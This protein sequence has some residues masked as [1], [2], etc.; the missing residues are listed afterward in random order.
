MLFHYL[1]SLIYVYSLYIY[2]GGS[3]SYQFTIKG[4]YHVKASNLSTHT[5][6]I[7]VLEHDMN[8]VTEDD[9]E[10]Q[11]SSSAFVVEQTRSNDD[12][13]ECSYKENFSEGLILSHASIM[14]VCFGILLPVGVFLAT[15]GSPFAHKI[16]QPGGLILTIV[17]YGLVFVYI[18][19]EEKNHFNSAHAILGFTLV[20]LTTLMP[21]LR[22]RKDLH[23]LHKKCGIVIVFYGM[24]NVLLVSAYETL[25]H[26][27]FLF[28]LGSS[29]YSMCSSVRQNTLW[30]LAVSIYGILC[31]MEE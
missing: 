17:G 10:Q 23:Y 5:H 19:V 27:I 1:K 22:L 24:A 30:S 18:E 6:S 28:L 4:V 25:V 16:F 11:C 26:I 8:N 12:C 2:T 21:L 29:Y 14:S 15:N 9:I 13:D 20:L 3:A 7:V 31:V